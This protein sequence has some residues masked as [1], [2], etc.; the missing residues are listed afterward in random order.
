VGCRPGVGAGADRGLEV[1]AEESSSPSIFIA[2]ESGEEAGEADSY[3]F[4]NILDI[5]AV[6]AVAAEQEGEEQASLLQEA[7]AEM[8][9]ASR[10]LLESSKDHLLDLLRFFYHPLHPPSRSKWD[11]NLKIQAR[12]LFG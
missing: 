2:G 1:G 3:N 10:S 12:F 11:R 6:V 7:V 8:A 4:H 5:A 9:V